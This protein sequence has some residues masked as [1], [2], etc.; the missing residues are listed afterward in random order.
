M[1][2]LIA[3]GVANRYSNHLVFPVHAGMSLP[4]LINEIQATC[5]P[6][7]A[8]MNRDGTYAQPTTCQCRQDQCGS[9]DRYQFPDDRWSI[10]TTL[11]SSQKD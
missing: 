5:F 1:E 3:D 11:E 8:G 2:W 4:E 10:Q 6:A 7:H 9:S